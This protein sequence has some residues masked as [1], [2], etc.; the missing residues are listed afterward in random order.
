[1]IFPPVLYLFIFCYIPM[2][3]LIIAFKDY[4]FNLGIFGSKWNGLDNFRFLFESN[5]FGTLV[6]NTIGYNFI[7]IIVGTISAIFVALML[8][9]MKNKIFIK[10]YQGSMFMPYF[11]SWIVV[12]Y[13]THALF[14]YESGL[15]NSIL[16]KMG[17]EGIS[18]YSEPKYWPYI[19]TILNV[20]KGIGYNSLVYYGTIL[21]IDPALFEAATIEGCS[22]IRKLWNITLPHLKPT[23][24]ILTL[25]SIGG[26]F[27]SDYGLF[28]YIPKDIGALY[29]ATDVLDTY[30]LRSIRSIGNMGAASAAGFL[31]SVVGCIVVV[32]M[33]GI[34]RK[35]DNENSLF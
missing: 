2:F 25:L 3:G 26:I 30:I 23:V 16:A 10:F 27:R 14:N 34:V 32:T 8:D 24:I 9:V 7:F 33:N 29:K 18:W 15:L 21:S 28:F 12:S 1:M 35:V 5:T 17:A 4:K 19:L 13:V 22:Y 6:K 11:L 20:W 31:Q